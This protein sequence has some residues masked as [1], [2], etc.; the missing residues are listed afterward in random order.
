MNTDLNCSSNIFAFSL[1]TLN[2][3]TNVLSGEIPIL[4][5]FQCSLTLTLKRFKFCALFIFF[6]FIEACFPPSLTLQFV[7]KQ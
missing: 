5:C 7:A 4:S 3:V 1:L 2:Q 6:M